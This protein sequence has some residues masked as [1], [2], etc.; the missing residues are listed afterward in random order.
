MQRRTAKT[1]AKWRFSLGLKGRRRSLAARNGSV[2]GN[3]RVRASAETRRRQPA[4]AGERFPFR[5]FCRTIAFESDGSAGQRPSHGIAAP[6][7]N[8]QWQWKKSDVTGSL[9]AR[10]TAARG[11]AA[12]SHGPIATLAGRPLLSNRGIPL[13]LDW[14]KQVRVNTSAVER[15]AQSHVLRRTVKKEWQVA[16]LLRAITCMDLTTLSGDDTDERVR[17]LCAK[18]RHPLTQDL[19]KASR[20][21]GTQC[22]GRGRVC[23]SPVCGD[24]AARAGRQRRAGGGGVDRI[25]GGAFAAGGARGRDSAIGGSRGAGHRRGHYAGACLRRTVAGTLRRDC[26]VQASLRQCAHEG[27]SRHG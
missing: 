5:Q 27:H 8:I 4:L 6:A 9:K 22:P 18:A 23:V 10:R 20:G 25:S 24:R 16:W 26:I 1:A 7:E 19:I 3:A 15:R 13:N 11:T 12:R 14:V 2:K 21:R 17:R